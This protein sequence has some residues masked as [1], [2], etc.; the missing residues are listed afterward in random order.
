MI[1]QPFGELTPSSHHHN[2]FFGQG[3][4]FDGDALLV[5]ARGYEWDPAT[6]NNVGAAFLFEN[7]GTQFTEIDLITP[8]VWQNGQF[9]GSSVALTCGQAVVGAP[10]WNEGTLSKAGSATFF[11]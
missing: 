11:Q 10:H 1:W 4:A 3:L 7:D 9:F 2:T 8:D 6:Q 5:G